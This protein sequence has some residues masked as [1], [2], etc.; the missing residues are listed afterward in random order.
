VLSKLGNPLHVRYKGYSVSFDT[1]EGQALCLD[2][3]LREG[4][5]GNRTD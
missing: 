2:G 5:S 3:Q 1:L 4:R